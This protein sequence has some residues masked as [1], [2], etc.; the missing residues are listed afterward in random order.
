[1]DILKQQLEEILL[2]LDASIVKLYYW[3]N[4][5]EFEKLPANDN[6]EQIKQKILRCLED[7]EHILKTGKDVTELVL[8]YIDQQH[9]N[10]T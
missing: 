7:L 5:Q 9:T 1:M 8:K 3:H 2:K 6:N 4:K 10:T